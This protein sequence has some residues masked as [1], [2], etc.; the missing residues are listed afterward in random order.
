MELPEMIIDDAPLDR[1][2]GGRVPGGDICSESVV[3]SS[4]K[5]HSKLARG[6]QLLAPC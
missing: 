3:Y 4:N 1:Y 6:V 5:H 2:A